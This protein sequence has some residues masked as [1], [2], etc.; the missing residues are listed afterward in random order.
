MSILASKFRQLTELSDKSPILRLNYEQFTDLV[1][2]APRNY[3][4]FS[5]LT[6]L[7]DQRKCH[8]CQAA[9]DEFNTLASSW[10]KLKNAKSKIFLLL[11]DFDENPKIFKELNQNTVPVFIHF[12]PSGSPSGADFLDISRSGFGAETLAR[13]IFSR[14]SVEIPII[15]QTSYA[16]AILLLII[17]GLV[18]AMLFLRPDNLEFIIHRSTLSY[19]VLIFYIISGQVWNSIRRP[20]FF[21]SPP[22]GGIVSS[23][24]SQTSTFRHFYTQ[25]ATFSSFRKRY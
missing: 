24:T 10:Q 17:A 23:N 6:A 1:R 3:S 20:P 2:G 8:S 9:N 18:G 13:W 22:Q 7:A 15:R 5:M 11:V 16:G 12:P 14:T 21:H 4:V 19:A 25:E